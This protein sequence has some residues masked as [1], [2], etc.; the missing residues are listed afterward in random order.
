MI[1]RKVRQHL[2]EHLK[3]NIAG[4]RQENKTYKWIFEILR[5]KN[6]KTF[7]SAVKRIG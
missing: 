2:D 6:V 7:L 1:P 5:E 4:K 3:N